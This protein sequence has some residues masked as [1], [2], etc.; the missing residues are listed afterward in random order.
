MGTRVVVG[1]ADLVVGRDGDLLVTHALGSCLGIVAHDPV[2][3]VGGMLHVMMPTSSINL[4]KA[5]LRPAMF[6]DTGV[7]RLFQECYAAG[8]RKERMIVKVAGG[9]ARAQAGETDSFQIGKRN[10][11][12]LRRLLWKNSVLI[13]G[14]EIG[15]TISRD[16]I[17]EVSTGEV[18][19][20]SGGRTWSI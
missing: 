18:T 4:E 10:M 8:A 17:Y 13:R 2:A 7:P 9:A 19:V 15:G 5:Q 20:R 3:R 1:I 16:L 6:V 14:Q 12:M 11:L